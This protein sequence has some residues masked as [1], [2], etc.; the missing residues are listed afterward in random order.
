M[1]HVRHKNDEN[2]EGAKYRF[3]WFLGTILS[4]V[5]YF[6]GIVWIFTLIRKRVLKKYISTVLMYHRIR[7]DNKDLDIS[8]TTRTFDRQMDYLKT[9]SD[10]VSLDTLIGNMK[11]KPSTK[12]DSFAITFDDGYSDN[13]S[14]AYFVLKKYKLPATIFLIT[15][16]IGKNA[17]MLNVDEIKKMENERITFGSHTANHQVLSKVSEEIATKEIVK[18]KSDME[19]IL[20]KKVKFFA[21]PKGKKHHF[22]VVIKTFVKN[23]GYEAAFTTENGQINEESDLFELKRIGIRNCPLFVFKV[24]VSGVFE[25]RIIYFIRNVFNMT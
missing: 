15:R 9:H 16:E 14:N 4:F 11:K 1:L 8:V 2:I 17:D 12:M 7:D 23:A 10:V 21:Y 19:A 6:S 5:L 24:R 25:S 20:N 13:Y 18:S 22:N 3:F